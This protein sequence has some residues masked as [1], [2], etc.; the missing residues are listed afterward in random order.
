VKQ[1]IIHRDVKSTNILLD[2]KWVAKVFDFG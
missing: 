1:K 2:D